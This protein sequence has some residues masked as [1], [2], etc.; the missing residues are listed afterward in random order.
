MSLVV[1]VTDHI[2]NVEGW[3]LRIFPTRIVPKR[4]WPIAVPD[5]RVESKVVPDRSTKLPG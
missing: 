4:G 3:C 5:H 1:A 2:Q